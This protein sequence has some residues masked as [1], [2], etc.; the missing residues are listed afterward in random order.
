MISE[1]LGPAG[2]GLLSSP[3]FLSFKV[4]SVVKCTVDVIVAFQGEKPHS[5]LIVYIK[6]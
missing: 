5:T 3:H 2:Q 6:F 1:E 4:P